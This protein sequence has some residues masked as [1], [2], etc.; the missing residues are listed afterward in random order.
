MN[1]SALNERNQMLAE[2]ERKKTNEL[3]NFIKM[4]PVFKKLSRS[5]LL[6]ITANLKRLVLIRKATVYNE[7]EPANWV[8][9]I[10]EGE[11]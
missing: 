1:Q 10:K 2:L 3:V 4:L 5:K 7:G 8:Y 6:Q 11:F 9:I